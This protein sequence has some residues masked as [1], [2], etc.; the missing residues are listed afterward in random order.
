MN[1]QLSAEILQSLAEFAARK[2]GSL[3]KVQLIASK[4][5]EKDPRT[6]LRCF[7]S[8]RAPA[9][10]RVSTELDRLELL[11]DAQNIRDQNLRRKALTEFSMGSFRFMGEFEW[12]FV[13]KMLASADGRK[14][15]T[16]WRN[17]VRMA[18]YAEGLEAA[19]QIH[20]GHEDLQ[21]KHV[22]MR[23]LIGVYPINTGDAAL[24]ASQ[25]VPVTEKELTEDKHR[26]LEVHASGLLRQRLAFAETFGSKNFLD[27]QLQ[28]EVLDRL[29]DYLNSMVSNGRPFSLVRFGEGERY[30]W[31]DSTDSDTFLE[32]H[33]WGRALD[34]TERNLVKSLGSAAFDRATGIGVPSVTRLL[35]DL[36][37]Q[38]RAAQRNWNHLIAITRQITEG[39]KRAELLFP[40]ELWNTRLG[41]EI[42]RHLVERSAK[43]LLV[44]PSFGPNSRIFSDGRVSPRLVQIVVPQHHSN[45]GRDDEFRPGDLV[46]EL[47]EVRQQ[48]AENVNPGDLV[49]VSAGAAGKIFCDDA[50]TL[51]G[52]GIDIGSAAHQIFGPQS[53]WSY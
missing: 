48:I 25:G 38:P 1:R 11:K 44:A 52:F 49:L 24:A 46:S 14:S 5:D 22:A 15:P 36:P 20:Q 13:P 43:T 39:T 8:R 28:Q 17:I 47:Q 51:Q 53:F 26:N 29:R 50:L 34:Q 9:F 37:T 12:S 40:T 32:R 16:T 41:Q 42:I 10:A 33:W 4:T 21:A 31:S 23:V 35:R 2:P 18:S 30:F 19:L 7:L 3:G 6:F 45:L 27:A